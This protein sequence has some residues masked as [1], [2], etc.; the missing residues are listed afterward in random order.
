[1]T[2]KKVINIFNTFIRNNL[3]HDWYLTNLRNRTKAH[4]LLIYFNFNNLKKLIELIYRKQKGC[5]P[6]S[7]PSEK[8]STDLLINT[9]ISWST[10]MTL[11]PY[12][13]YSSWTSASKALNTRN[14]FPI[15]RDDI[16]LPWVHLVLYSWI[17]LYF[18]FINILHNNSHQ[19][20]DNL[21]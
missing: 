8:N 18:Y 15:K 4:V 17:D 12:F 11:K 10:K 2:L 13:I 16:I 14:Q 3:Q 5:S 21:V 6:I 20:L 1:M 9:M 7:S 19:R